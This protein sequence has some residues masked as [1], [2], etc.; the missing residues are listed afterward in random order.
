MQNVTQSAKKYRIDRKR[1]RE[2][3]EK[4]DKLLDAYIGK[5][6]KRRKLTAVEH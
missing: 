3:N 6:R 2:W 1:V 5:G 4:Y